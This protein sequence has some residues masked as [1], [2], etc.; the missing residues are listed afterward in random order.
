[1]AGIE[2]SAT[3]LDRLVDEGRLVG[4]VLGL[5]ENGRTRIVAGGAST[6]GGAA[7]GEDAQFPLTSNTKP[8][9]GAL[10]MRLVELGVLTLDAPVDEHLPELA[11]PHVLV[12][13]DGPLDEVVAADRP[14]TLRH[15]LT[16]TPG[17]GWVTETGP[18]ST[19][20]EQRRISPG[21]YPPPMRPEEYLTRLGEL[22]LADQPGRHWRYHNSSDVLGV[23]VARATDRPVSELLGEYVFGPCGMSETG[24]VGD[25]ERMPTSY[26]ADADGN[27]GELALPEGVFRTPPE[28]ESLACGLVSTVGDYLRFLAVLSEGAPVL[29]RGSVIQMGTDQLTAGQRE[30]AAEFLEPGSGYGFHVEIRPDGSVGWAGGLGTIGYT[31]PLTGRSAALFTAQSF[32]APGTA[33]AF[34]KFWPLLR[35][36]TVAATTA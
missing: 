19:A 28:F 1:M 10:A 17:F 5:G 8:I 32:E 7:M 15:L 30:T 2:H 36:P 16:M 11:H 18:L 21:P 14:I 33:D 22:P 3:A 20:M 25:P 34:E 12:R 26:G 23:L 31:N 13:P 9:G 35:W 6:L 29:S 4:Y 27:L 24:F